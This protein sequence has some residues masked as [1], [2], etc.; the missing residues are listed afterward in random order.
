M[1]TAELAGEKPGDIMSLKQS[2]E[3]YLLGEDKVIN[4]LD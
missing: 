1:E 4:Y 3:N 2:A